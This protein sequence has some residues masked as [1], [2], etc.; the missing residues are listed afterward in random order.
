MKR[1]GMV[2]QIKPEKIKEYKELHAKVW[3]DVLAVISSFNIKNYSIYL[4]EPENLLFSYFEYHGTDFDLDMAKMASDPI[5]KEWWLCTD[6][7]QEP[8]QTKSHH[9]WWSEMEEVFHSD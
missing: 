6:P 3:P 7:C 1:Y 5:I 8:L 4:R 2:I 9:E